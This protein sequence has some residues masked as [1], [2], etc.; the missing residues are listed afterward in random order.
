MHLSLTLLLLVF[1]KN[2]Y[3][4][5]SKI[6]IEIK[7]FDNNT[8]LIF[9]HDKNQQI[10]INYKDKLV[11]ANLSLPGEFTLLSPDKFNQLANT[12]T[13]NKEKTVITVSLKQEYAFSSIINGEKLTAIKFRN[14]T[15]PSDENL[16]QTQK[17][18]INDT[19]DQGFRNNATTVRY[20]N[21][22][23]EHKLSFDFTGMQDLPGVASFFRGKYLWV[24]FD[25]FRVFN[26][27]NQEIFTEFT[28][29]QNDNN[30][31][32]RMKVNG[33]SNAS[34]TKNGAIW[35][36]RV[37][38]NPVNDK[39]RIITTKMLDNKDG[40][41]MDGISGDNQIIEIEDKNIGDIIKVLTTKTSGLRV[42]AI[43]EFI[44]F[45]I[46]PSVQGVVA[47]ISSNDN[48]EFIKDKNTLKVISKN[49]T[50][51]AVNDSATNRNVRLDRQ[52]SDSLLPK[53]KDF[54]NDNFVNIKNQLT[55]DIINSDD[56]KNQLYDKRLRLAKL[57]FAYGLYKESVG[58][59]YL[60]EKITQTQYQNDLKTQFITAVNNTLTRK[61]DDATAIYQQLFKTIDIQ[62]SDEINLWNNY[63][64]F[65]A[66]KNPAYIGFAGAKFVN[67]YPD[68][69]YWAIAFAEIELSLLANNIKT[70][71]T[72]FKELRTPPVGKYANS[73]QFYKAHYYKKT[74][75]IN[76]AKQFLK[77]LA[78]KTDDPFNMMRS[79]VELLKLQKEKGEVS[80]SD[81]AKKLESLRFTWR[82]DILEYN[83]LLL[84]AGYYRDMHDSLNA[85]RTYKY[86]ASV[87]NNKISNFYI[88][89]EMVKIFN[90]IFVQ[91]N[92][93]NKMQP[94]DAVAL[95]YEFKDLNP[96]GAEGDA[97]ILSIAK[98]LMQ[99]DLLDQ[100]VE[101][102]QHQVEYRLSG[103]KRVINADHLAI[104][105]LMNKKPLEAIKA[106]DETDKDNF[107]FNEHQYRRRLKAKAL[108][109]LGRYNESLESLA[110][111]LS[112]DAAVL[113]K[114][115][116]FRA[117]K[118]Q[119]YINFVAPN[120]QA[121]LL[122]GKISD[123]ATTQDVLRLAI[124]Y[125]MTNDQA[126]LAALSN[127][128]DTGNDSLKSTIELLLISGKPVDYGNL[129]QSLN[130]NQMQILLD[131]YK[132]QL[133]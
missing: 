72:V 29:L 128:L 4:A 47:V 53:I 64:D 103:E 87:F 46:L 131:K 74:N 45:S 40:V 43:T 28:Q 55:F 79:N 99:L 107:R 119:E 86:I 117:E 17:D 9:Y 58:T 20:V 97:V 52:A 101:L 127:N 23:G 121:Q 73:L 10:T 37:N 7:T 39:Q 13:I 14:E 133:F 19:N 42:P 78:Q 26:L 30:T 96:I 88:T 63:N 81:A 124:A 62:S 34:I 104:A 54:D 129:D 105:L 82:G 6:D 51:N 60:L 112:D 76:L 80:L 95:F 98:M 111:D 90:S 22:N 16:V 85:L 91:G 75:Q 32:L 57:F 71:E 38:N 110:K 113:K 89:S 65:L 12:A 41:A 126:D 118:W 106:L 69:I 2:V 123:K 67:S 94:F 24:I 3:A 21:N 83:T 11:T 114:E 77:D 68:D 100:T 108:I 109:D 130:V 116:M 18:Q 92:S 44:D 33:Y 122:Q 25:K 132:N 125:Y 93:I 84:L 70:I 61:L 31:I 1:C 49:N 50:G 15:D 59:M 115:A 56:D 36:V 35:N 102:L 5:E 8:V 48:V 27:S 66:N 120:V